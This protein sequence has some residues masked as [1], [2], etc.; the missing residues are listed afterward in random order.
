MRQ[1]IPNDPFSFVP[2]WRRN[3]QC[4]SVAAAVAATDADGATV[5]RRRAGRARG[6]S[7]AEDPLHQGLLPFD[8][9]NNNKE[10]KS[11]S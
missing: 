5:A 11:S 3:G 7:P 6:Q 10:K 1:D 8:N 4:L 9:I 2:G